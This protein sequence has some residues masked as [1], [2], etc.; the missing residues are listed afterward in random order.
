MAITESLAGTFGTKESSVSTARQAVLL[1]RE[2]KESS[3]AIA[4]HAVLPTLEEGFGLPIWIDGARPQPGKLIIVVKEVITGLSC[5]AVFLDEWTVRKMLQD[6][7]T[8]RQYDRREGGDVAMTFEVYEDGVS[9]DPA[10]RVVGHR[11]GNV[12]SLRF[13]IDNVD[14]MKLLAK[15]PTV[16]RRA[17]LYADEVVLSQARIDGDKAGVRA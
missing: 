15:A 5:S 9:T 3:R 14:W 11:Q 17:K 13:S 8:L 12:D 1:T 7:V 4:R 10:T 6:Y 2:T 16:E